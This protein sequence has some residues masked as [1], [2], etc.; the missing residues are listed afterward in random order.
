[1]LFAMYCI[2]YRTPLIA[3]DYRYLWLS[4]QKNFDY[5][6]MGPPAA[7]SPLHGLLFFLFIKLG[8]LKSGLI[9]GLILLF[10]IHAAA[11]YLIAL[12]LLV[13][14]RNFTGAGFSLSPFLPV[15]TIPF[16]FHPNFLEVL[17]MAMSAVVA[18]GALFMALAFWARNRFFVFLFSLLAFASYETF[19]LP[20][21]SFFFLNALAVKAPGKKG[22][23][24]E[25]VWFATPLISGFLLY[26]SLRF[27]LGNYFGT[28][29][30][31]FNLDL[32]HNLRRIIRYHVQVFTVG[33]DHSFSTIAETMVFLSGLGIIL[34]RKDRRM[35]LL[36]VAGILLAGFFSS[37]VDLLVPYDGIRVI[38]GSYFF[39]VSALICVFYT[40]LSDYRFSWFLLPAVILIPVFSKN[41]MS[42][43]RIR[44]HSY[45]NQQD[46]HRLISGIFQKAETSRSLLLPPNTLHSHPDD[47]ALEP[48]SIIQYK[49][50]RHLLY[51][52]RELAFRVF[53]YDSMTFQP[54][55][56]PVFYPSRSF[57]YNIGS[58]WERDNRSRTGQVYR[59]EK[60]TYGK[61]VFGPYISLDSGRYKLELVYRYGS[62]VPQNPE[63]GGVEVTAEKGRKFISSQPFV[64]NAA[65]PVVFKKIQHSF[66]LAGPENDVEFSI[67]SN[68]QIDFF[69]DYMKI[70][71][72]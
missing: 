28:Y 29:V 41:L 40:A 38:Y 39:K 61:A 11:V 3:D 69:I 20:I 22:L 7:R 25:M 72:F 15:L 51:G 70:S 4:T 67:F 21:F 57:V 49:L 33:Y 34:F 65:D 35:V 31:P 54:G 48:N 10:T 59:I 47:W 46:I 44:Q 45:L 8:Y 24:A 12:R 19:I 5:Q 9:P 36:P 17:F 63:F 6:G 52:E 26:L 53:G 13:L 1:L 50:Y 62:A 37:A 42:I 14:I 18:F 68:G 27:F 60:G 2:W 64:F 43:Y 66:E 55:D 58:T 23:K 16:S 56:L 30:Q 71:R 32:V